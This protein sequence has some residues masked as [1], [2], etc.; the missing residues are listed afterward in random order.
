M[1]G[2]IIGDIVGSRF[3]GDDFKS[4]DFNLFAPECRPTDDTV[5]TLAVGDALLAYR[6][7][8]GDLRE[9]AVKKM[10]TSDWM[11]FVTPMA[12]RSHAEIRFRRRLRRSWSRMV[13]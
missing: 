6:E 12:L 5:M 11:R 13:L 3:E 4:K 10:P 8:G 7:E 2:A 9:H 1:I